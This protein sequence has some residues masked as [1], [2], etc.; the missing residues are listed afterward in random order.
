MRPQLRKTKKKKKLKTNI[1]CL[2]VLNAT[3]APPKKKADIALKNAA[4]DVFYG[5]V[6]KTRLHVF[7]LSRVFL[8]W[9]FSPFGAA[10][11]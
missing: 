8:K 3:V 4:L 10:F 11:L 7:S 9:G 2:C 1:L 5:P 6:Y